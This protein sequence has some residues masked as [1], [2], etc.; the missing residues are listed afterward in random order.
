MHL[1]RR[2]QRATLK[3]VTRD[4]VRLVPL[5]A[6]ALLAFLPVFN[7]CTKPACYYDVGLYYLQKIRWLQTFPIVPGLGNLLLNLGYNHSAF[8]V[9]SFLDSLLPPDRPLVGRWIV[10]LAGPYSCGL[11][12]DPPS[13]SAPG[14]TVP[15]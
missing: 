7:T 12:V 5:G 11:C 8:L 14:A 15:A 6:I 10:A 9:T 4:W 3:D 2:A 13:I 1:W